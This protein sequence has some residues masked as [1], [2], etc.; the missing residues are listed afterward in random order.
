MTP[1]AFWL[2]P[3][4]KIQLTKDESGTTKGIQK[5]KATNA[6]SN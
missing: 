5:K 3:Q 1:Y 2:S 4:I 6:E